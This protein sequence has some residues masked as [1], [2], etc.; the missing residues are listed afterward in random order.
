MNRRQPNR[1]VFI[2]LLL[3]VSHAIARDPGFPVGERLL[4]DL[5]WG[6]LPVGRAEIC[7]EWTADDPPL[8]R[9]RVH[10]RSNAFLDRIYKIDDTVESL[11]DPSECLPIRFEKSLHEGG[12][13][14]RDVTYYDRA[15]GFVIWHNYLK[16][17]QRIFPAPADVR[18]ILTLMYS[19][20]AAEFR[21]GT[22][23]WYVV[24]GEESAVEVGIAVRAKRTF[25]HER[26]GKIPAYW[27]RPIVGNDPLFLGRIPRELW[28]SATP[29]YVLLRLTVEAPVGRVHL[30]LNQIDGFDSGPWPYREPADE[31]PR[32]EQG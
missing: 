14:R 28:I 11:V 29:P 20:R 12:V 31:P 18:D 1:L 22:T 10:V 5:S 8:I 26:Y 25:L 30:T 7:S 2:V 32:E 21:V 17:E 15:S 23:N 6:I 4:F 16:P 24:A 13:P 3:L 9:L 27:L 19:L